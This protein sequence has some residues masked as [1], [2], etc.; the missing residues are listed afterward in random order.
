MLKDKTLHLFVFADALGWK[1]AQE[2]N[3]LTD[4]L[5]HR[6]E[7]ET[8]L[9]YS[10]TCDPTI[11][12][13]VQP[14]EHGHFSFYVFDPAHS[15]FGWARWLGWL[16]QQVAAYHRIRNR[17][18]RWTAARMG[19]T[20]YFQLYSVPFNRLPWLNYT[21]KHDIYEPGGILGGQET[22][23]AK[24][25][26]RGLPWMRSDWRRS[27]AENVAQLLTAVDQGD[28]RL[29]YLFTS[30]LDAIMHKHGTSHAAVDEA[31]ARF[32][33]W[34]RQI[35][36]RSSKHYSEV[37]LHVFS[38]HG[39]ID[40]KQSSSLLPEFERLGLRYGHDYAAVWDST[41][42]R[43]W[44]PGGAAVREQITQWLAQQPAG[45]ILSDDELKRWHCYFPDHRYG[46]LFYLLP[47]GT[48]FAPSYMNRGFVRGM[49]GFSPDE[50]G[51]AACLLSSHP[52]TCR[53]TQLR[54]LH[55]LMV[56]AMR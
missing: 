1:L 14:D 37:R 17:V 10:C 44:F 53:V 49:H 20:G 50:P 32:A 27:D 47:S 26:R 54:D 46:E 13:G 23:F 31:F 41:M 34:L 8:L 42:V 43:F 6:A 24:W 48:I 7:V 56:D 15:P 30:G 3:F 5:P 22:I 16:P 39:M 25:A 11:L 2:R 36:E 51:N 55:Q 28:I 40:T 12:T 29:A 45:R 35:C 19:Y 9:G 18:S 33:G 21:E 4:L 52:P 38:D